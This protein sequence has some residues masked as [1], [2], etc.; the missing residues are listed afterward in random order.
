MLQKLYAKGLGL[1]NLGLSLVIAAPADSSVIRLDCTAVKLPGA[2][3]EKTPL[4][5]C[6]LPKI[7]THSNGI[8]WSAGP[9]A[10]DGKV[11][12]DGAAVE[13][14]RGNKNKIITQGSHGL[15]LAI[16]T[17][18]GQRTAGPASTTMGVPHTHL[19]EVGPRGER[20]ARKSVTP[21]GKSSTGG[22]A[23]GCILGGIYLQK[24]TRR[25]VQLPLMIAPPAEEAVVGIDHT[26]VKIS[27][28]Q[29][30]N[31]A[32][33]GD[34]LSEMR[35]LVNWIVGFSRPP[36]EGCSQE[37]HAATVVAP[38]TQLGQSSKG[39]PE[40]MIRIL[41]PA[42]GESINPQHAGVRRPRS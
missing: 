14:A 23:A 40:L 37:I 19:S 2:Q 3:I 39:R 28:G 7:R 34:G 17:P 18:T 36:A 26:V 20:C 32:Y 29:V 6:R 35:I 25:G 41:P 33:R 15:A 24:M 9:P 4:R 22:N 30:H 13:P 8:P 10:N 38:N 31:F 16:V 11:F 1:G 27:G 12:F 5:R 21:A 42:G